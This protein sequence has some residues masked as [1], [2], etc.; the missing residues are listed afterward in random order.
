MKQDKLTIHQ[1]LETQRSSEP[2]EAFI[3]G[4]LILTSSL[5]SVLFYADFHL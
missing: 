5:I 3:I 4:A 1:V 2:F